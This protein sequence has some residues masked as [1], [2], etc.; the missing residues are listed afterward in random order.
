MVALSFGKVCKSVCFLVTAQNSLKWRVIFTEAETR[1][2]QLHHKYTI[3][4]CLCQYGILPEKMKKK[5]VSLF[6]YTPLSCFTA[7]LVGR[8][9]VF[10][11]ALNKNTFF[12]WLQLLHVHVQ[13][14]SRCV[15]VQ[16]SQCPFL[17]NFIFTWSSPGPIL[18]Q[19]ITTVLFQTN[20]IIHV[21]YVH[22]EHLQS[23]TG[24][25]KQ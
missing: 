10:S 23:C 20:K 15:L 25:S 17:S 1:C 4:E 16:L 2:T 9:L 24:L 7:F 14:A 18:Q 3:F 21:D 8:L 5:E 19:I 13:T 22:M 11:G 12:S 6:R